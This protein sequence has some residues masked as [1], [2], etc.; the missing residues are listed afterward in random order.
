MA[1]ISSFAVAPESAL[2]ADSA[3]PTVRRYRL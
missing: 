1:M 3:A 2:L